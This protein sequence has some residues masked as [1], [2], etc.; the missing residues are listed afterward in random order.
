MRPAGH[1]GA[2]D[3]DPEAF[4]HVFSFEKSAEAERLNRRMVM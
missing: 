1:S 2:D 4:G 3:G